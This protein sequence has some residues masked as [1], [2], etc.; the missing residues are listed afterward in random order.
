MEI[1][2]KG[3]GAF[4][5]ALVQLQ[6]GESFCS[7]SGAMYRAS[8]NV[9]IDVTTRSRG[10][11]GVMSGI[12]RLLSKESFFLSTYKTSDGA[13]GEVGLAPTHQGMVHVIEM[14]G[15]SDWFCTGGS[16]LGSTPGLELDTQFQGLKGLF[17]GEAPFFVKVTGAGTLVVTAYG[18]IVETDVSESLTVDTGH[19]VAFEVGLEYSLEK[20]GASWFQSWLAGEGI[21]LK[22]AGRG[23]VITQSHNP[24]EFGRRL[25]PKL[26]DRSG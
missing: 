12:K 9:D 14:D 22:F 15:T 4:E 8:H 5:S 7:E 24:K 1:T 6:P 11:G 26:P 17:S 20:A 19:V 23:I 3:K 13:A 16:Y 2:I 18:R 21:V 10:K 25:G